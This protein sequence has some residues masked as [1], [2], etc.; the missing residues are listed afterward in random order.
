MPCN[1][2][3]RLVLL[4]SG[5]LAET[6]LIRCHLPMPQGPVF[7]KASAEMDRSVL[8]GRQGTVTTWHETIGAIVQGG[9]SLIK[10]SSDGD[11]EIQAARREWTTI[12]ELR[13]LIMSQ[14]NWHNLESPVQGSLF[15]YAHN[16]KYVSVRA[17]DFP[18][19]LPAGVEHYILWTRVSAITREAFA[20]RDGE[21]VP[22]HSFNDPS[23]VEALIRYVEHYDFY[24]WYGIHDEDVENSF[25]LSSFAHATNPVWHDPESDHTVTREQGAAVMKWLGRHVAAAIQPHFPEDEFQVLF[26]RSPA[27]WKS[28]VD[29]DH[30][31]IFALPK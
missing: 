21:A 26:N 9:G 2:L 10:R 24:G 8:Y 11:R 31:H 16:P 14:N 20:P 23:R 12:D 18:Y 17:N 4:L 29:P 5:L 6:G 7:G 27:R 13:D 22:D 1:N 28:V 19:D 30:F 25:A 15:E 3:P